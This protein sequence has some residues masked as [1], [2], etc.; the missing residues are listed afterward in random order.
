MH[1]LGSAEKAAGV[2]KDLLWN[3]SQAIRKTCVSGSAPSAKSAWCLDAAGMSAALPIWEAPV[4][5]HPTQAAAQRWKLCWD[6]CSRLGFVSSLAVQGA[7][8]TC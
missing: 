7:E 4:A 5:T 2:N 8:Q 6:P 3:P 1:K